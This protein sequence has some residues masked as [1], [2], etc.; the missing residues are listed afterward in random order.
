MTGTPKEN[1]KETVFNAKNQCCQLQ[2]REWTYKW[3]STLL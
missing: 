3:P 1:L 2:D